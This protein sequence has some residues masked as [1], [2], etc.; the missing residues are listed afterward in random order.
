MKTTRDE[1]IAAVFGGFESLMVH[2]WKI[3]TTYSH[4]NKIDCT[5]LY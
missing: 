2:L 1:V 5:G 4:Q 3:K